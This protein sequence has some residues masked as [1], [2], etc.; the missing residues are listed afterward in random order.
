MKLPWSLCPFC[1]TPDPGKRIEDLTVSEASR[2]MEVPE[3]EEDLEEEI[4]DFESEDME[5]LSD[6]DLIDQ[7]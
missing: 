4:P 6:E 5:E 7:L 2:S 1:G 3:V